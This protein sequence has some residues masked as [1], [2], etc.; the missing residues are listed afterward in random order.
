MTA[1]LAAVWTAWRRS[2]PSPWATTSNK[3]LNFLQHVKSCLKIHGRAAIVV[4]D[5]VLFEGGA[6]ETIGRELLKQGDVHTLL[7]PPTGIFYAQ[8][9]KAN[10]LFFDRRPASETPWTKTLWIYD[11][12]TNEHFTLKTNPPKHAD[13]D[14]FVSRY[15]VPVVGVTSPLHQLQV[16]ALPLGVAYTCSA[17]LPQTANDI[18]SFAADTN[19]RHGLRALLWQIFKQ[20][21]IRFLHLRKHDPNR[22]VFDHT[23]RMDKLMDNDHF[24]L[25]FRSLHLAGKKNRREE[26]VLEVVVRE[27][28][29]LSVKM[30]RLEVVI[31]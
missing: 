19:R 11:F 1:R 24:P 13:L 27:R 12:R 6:G 20:T 21:A 25:L 29:G 28:G 7:R 22:V 5:N 3:Q 26:S 10:V 17:A 30:I 18:R 8:G 16:P 4:P 31:G 9:V 23:G 2:R 15:E 14:D